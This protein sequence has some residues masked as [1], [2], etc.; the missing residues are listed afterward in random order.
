MRT[1]FRSM[2]ALTVLL[3]VSLGTATQTS[4]QTSG[5]TGGQNLPRLDYTISIADAPRHLFHIKI[6]VT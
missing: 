6:A 2:A 5:Q 3:L 1:S 4:G